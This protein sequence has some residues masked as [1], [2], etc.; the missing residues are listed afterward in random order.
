M[1]PKV[2]LR[3]GDAI[4]FMVQEG[5]VIHYSWNMALPHIEFVRRKTGA[6]PEGRV[7]G[8]GDEAGGRSDGNHL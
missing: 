1:N 5:Q 2:Q 6:L 4:L 7:G 3:N 8:H